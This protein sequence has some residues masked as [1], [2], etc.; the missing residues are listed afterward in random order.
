MTYNKKECEDIQ[1]FFR[2][3]L[4]HLTKNVGQN[5]RGIELIKDYLKIINEKLDKLYE[6]S[7]N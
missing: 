4:Y 5:R 2:W 1:G 3:Q 7:P 6:T